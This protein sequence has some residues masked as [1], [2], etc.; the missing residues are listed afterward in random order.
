MVQVVTSAL[1]CRTSIHEDVK[2]VVRV[3]AEVV[4]VGRVPVNPALDV[5]ARGGG[6]ID[7]HT[8]GILDAGSQTGRCG[9]DT[10]DRGGASS[11]HTLP[12]VPLGITC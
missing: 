2:H 9:G 10:R 11:V 12:N 1:T 7:P 5:R 3:A 8:A 6:D 4:E